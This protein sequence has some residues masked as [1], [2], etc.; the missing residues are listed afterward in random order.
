MTIRK[1]I[2]KFT[3]L[4]LWWGSAVIVVFKVTNHM[5]HWLETQLPSNLHEIPWYPIRE[6][7]YSFAGIVYIIAPTGLIIWLT[8]EGIKK[9]WEM[10]KK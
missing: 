3:I 6:I 2:R 10:S 1:R 5:G 8:Y 4:L 9:L 7:F